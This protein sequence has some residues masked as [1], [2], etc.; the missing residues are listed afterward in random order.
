MTLG[1]IDLVGHLDQGHFAVSTD[2]EADK[3]LNTSCECTLQLHNYLTSH[4][5]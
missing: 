5:L 1:G 3:P 4:D 2:S